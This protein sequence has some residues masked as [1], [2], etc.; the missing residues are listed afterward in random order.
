M[1]QWF[2]PLDQVIDCRLNKL[3]KRLQV[4]SEIK[5]Y[6]NIF[7][8]GQ[9]CQ[10]HSCGSEEGFI[11]LDDNKKKAWAIY[12]SDES[13]RIKGKFFGKL[14]VSD[15]IPKRIIEA[16]LVEHEISW[17]QLAIYNEIPAVKDKNTP[18]TEGSSV[19]MTFE[20][21]VYK[22]PVTI[23]GIIPVAFVVD[24]GASDV[25]I[26]SDVVSVMLR[27]GTLTSGDF[28]GTKTY[29]LANGSAVPSNTFRIKSIKV[30][31]QIVENIDASMTGPDGVLLL[32]QSFLRKF[33]KWSIN[34]KNHTLEL[35]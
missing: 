20:G 31:N 34:N 14:D 5:N 15:V 18:I 23:N 8:V 1:I 22:I 27:T 29:K 3:R 35:E 19:Q 2:M 28:T 33:R 30:G 10:K 6:S 7:Y 13:G 24:S 17:D 4:V 11:I 32:G 25:V 12:I 26:P 16:W 9:G 21:G